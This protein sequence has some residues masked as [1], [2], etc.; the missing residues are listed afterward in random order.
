MLLLPYATYVWS[1]KL[2]YRKCV[3]V[4]S[5]I[6][7]FA[8]LRVIEKLSSSNTPKQTQSQLYVNKTDIIYFQTPEKIAL[9]YKV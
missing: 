3:V 4:N 1:L 7:Y 5:K 2:L 8:L 9:Q 6:T